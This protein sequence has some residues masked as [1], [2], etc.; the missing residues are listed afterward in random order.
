[1]PKRA[2]IERVLE[3]LCYGVRRAIARSVFGLLSEGHYLLACI[4]NT[5]IH[6]RVSDRSV[7]GQ[8]VASLSWRLV[9]LLDLRGC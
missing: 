6:I 4:L 9:W 2:S 3:K 7:G 5:R 8:W 1:M